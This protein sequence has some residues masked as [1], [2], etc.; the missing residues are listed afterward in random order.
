MSELTMT[1]RE[2]ERRESAAYQD[3]PT[4]LFPNSHA[5]NHA[6]DLKFHVSFGQNWEDLTEKQ[7]VE[8]GGG[9]LHSSQFD[10]WYED[11]EPLAVDDDGDDEYWDPAD[12]ALLDGFLPDYSA[13]GEEPF[14]GSEN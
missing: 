10:F 1:D 5:P 8:R 13:E 7:I 12:R 2:Y 6:P 4:C 11:A 14:P 3:S 9:F